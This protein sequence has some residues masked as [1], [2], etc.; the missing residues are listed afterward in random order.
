MPNFQNNV[1]RKACCSSR[2]EN[3]NISKN[4]SFALRD[5]HHA[6]VTARLWAVI[7]DS[8]VEMTQG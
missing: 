3:T 4:L 7:E 6:I 5:T 1:I 2:C 8:I